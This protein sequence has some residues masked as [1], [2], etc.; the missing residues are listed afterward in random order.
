MKDRTSTCFI[1]AQ[2]GHRSILLMLLSAGAN[3][4]VPRNDGA[5]P[6]WIAAQIGHDHIV[7]ILLQNG[8]KVDALRDGSTP[9]FKASHKGHSAV[10]AE[11]LKYRPHLGILPVFIKFRSNFKFLTDNF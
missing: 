2:N 6:L 1:A 4:D 10:C 5:T 8:A 11:I 9:L 3:C 7:K